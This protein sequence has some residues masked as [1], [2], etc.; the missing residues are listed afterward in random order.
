MLKLVPKS[1]R[2]RMNHNLARVVS[3]GAPVSVLEAKTIQLGRN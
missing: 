3:A 1:T 2:F